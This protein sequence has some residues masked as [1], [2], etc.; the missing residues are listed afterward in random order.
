VKTLSP[1][2]PANISPYASACFRAL[3]ESGLSGYLSIGGALGLFH[4]FEY[5]FTHDADA[6]WHAEAGQEQRRQVVQV[7]ETALRS[8]GQTRTRKWGDVVSVE[9]MQA[10]KTVFSFQIASRDVQLR[11]WVWLEEE[12]IALDSLPDLIASK[13]TALVER[14]APRDFLD[15]F[16]L[17]SQNIVEPVECWSLWQ[18]RQARSGD[19]TDFERARLA[20]ETHLERIA[21]HRPL[22]SIPDTEQRMKAETLRR[23]FRESFLNT[24]HE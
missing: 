20:I 10:D 24:E 2:R 14:G 15:I 1:R 9:L 23:W 21:L 8:F 3:R 12:G 19:N 11:N 22:E 16:T 13:M 17:C 5:R 6:W 18:E 4:Y 7:I